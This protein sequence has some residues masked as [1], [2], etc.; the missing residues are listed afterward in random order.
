MN[1]HNTIPRLHG[2]CKFCK[3]FWVLV[4]N[5]PLRFVASGT[6]TIVYFLP[7]MFEFREKSF[8]KKCS[9]C[10][11]AFQFTGVQYE[12]LVH[13]SQHRIEYFPTMFQILL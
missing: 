2:N 12:I 8:L 7:T 10:H 4:R 9:H 5:V 1:N 11:V 13:L 6:S 3:L